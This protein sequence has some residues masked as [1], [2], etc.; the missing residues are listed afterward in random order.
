MAAQTRMSGAKVRRWA[1][2]AMTFTGSDREAD[3]DF[4]IYAICA[5]T[6]QPHQWLQ[7]VQDHEASA[8]E[9]RRAIRATTPLSSAD[10]TRRGESLLHQSKRWWR[11]APLESRAILAP[12]WSLFEAER[13]QSQHGDE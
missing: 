11:D 4:E 8:Q 2:T 1:T 7:W 5:Q 12:L 6:D 13:V 10:W 3:V 9:L